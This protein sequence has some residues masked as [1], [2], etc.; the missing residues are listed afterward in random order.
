MNPD[1]RRRVRDKLIRRALSGQNL[2]AWLP[3]GDHDAARSAVVSGCGGGS[4]VEGLFWQ[5]CRHGVGAFDWDLPSRSD[6]SIA[7]VFVKWREIL[8]TVAQGVNP[9]R[10]AEL[11]RASKVRFDWHHEHR[12]DW[13]SGNRHLSE[14]DRRQLIDERIESWSA[15]NGPYEAA[16]KAIIEAGLA[17]EQEM[18]LF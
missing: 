9:E 10:L 12:D 11:E 3:G 14:D 1:E 8:D 2:Q 15:M 18:T 7:T 6:P 17:A 16:T 4:L 5:T 13:R